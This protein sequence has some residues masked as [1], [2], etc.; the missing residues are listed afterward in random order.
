MLVHLA[1]PPQ[2]LDGEEAAG[3]GPLRRW[4]EGDRTQPVPSAPCPSS[5]VTKAKCGAGHSGT[6][7]CG[8]HGGGSATVLPDSRGGRCETSGSQ[9]GRSPTRAVRD[10]QLSDEL[11]RQQCGQR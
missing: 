4:L 10:Q 9:R 7:F 11:F 5:P 8:L 1:D 2:R 6:V 3:A